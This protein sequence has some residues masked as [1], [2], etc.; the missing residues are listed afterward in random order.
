MPYKD[1][2]KE[3]SGNRKEG[4]CLEAAVMSMQA[5][6]SVGEFILVASISDSENAELACYY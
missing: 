4:A 3:L 2:R 5:E 1:S 6:M